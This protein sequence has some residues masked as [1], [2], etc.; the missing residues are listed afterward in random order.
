VDTFLLRVF[1][2]QVAD[3]CRFVMASVPIINQA[4]STGNHDSLWMGCQMFVVGAG[5]ASKALWGEGRSRSTIAPHRQRLRDSLG[6]TDTSP[7]YKL[8]IRN[9]FEHYDERIDR[10]W[11]NSVHHNLLDRMIG[12][13]GMVSGLADVDMFR[14]F[15]PATG[16][17]FFWGEQYPLQPIA[18][19]CERILPLAETEAAKPPWSE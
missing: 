15:D 12:P 3:Q 1:Q 10:W 17:I 16:S 2:R 19:E 13:P 4:S 5:N 9:H 11:A 8:D 6:V 18:T 7:L 14:V